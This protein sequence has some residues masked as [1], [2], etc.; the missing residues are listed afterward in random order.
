MNDHFLPEKLILDH[1]RSN[2]STVKS[3]EI[4]SYSDMVSADKCSLTDISIK[5]LLHDDI[6]FQNDDKRPSHRQ[7]TDQFWIIAVSYQEVSDCSGETARSKAGEIVSEVMLLMHNWDADCFL[8]R[9]ER[10]KSP[11]RPT[12][13]NGKMTFP[14]MFKTRFSI[15]GNKNERS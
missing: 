1:L 8:H 6:P 5:V 4:E 11:F 3:F 13:K 9:F 2:M 12:F 15:Q 10:V 14:M 7:L